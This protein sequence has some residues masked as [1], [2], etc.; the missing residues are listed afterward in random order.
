MKKIYCILILFLICGCAKLPENTNK[1]IEDALIEKAQRIGLYLVAAK[2]AEEEGNSQASVYL[3]E[4]AEEEIE[5]IKNLS[6]I[7]ART[8]RNAQS[9]I[10]KIMQIEKNAARSK[11][12]KMARNAHDEDKEE[13]ADLFKKM[14]QDEER[15]YSGLR[16]I[17]KKN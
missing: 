17:R 7:Q 10:K 15:H 3:C 8:G 1:N 14:A 13:V 12:P 4:L 5:H 16:G 11:Y 6:I 9:S 2:Q